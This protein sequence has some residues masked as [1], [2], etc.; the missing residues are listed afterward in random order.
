MPWGPPTAIQ[1]LKSTAQYV[2]A[3]RKMASSVPAASVSVSVNWVRWGKTISKMRDIA[4]TLMMLRQA[5][6]TWSRTE[7]PRR[8]RTT[9]MQ[10]QTVAV[11]EMPRATTTPRKPK[12]SAPI[13][14]RGNLTEI[15]KRFRLKKIL[16]CPNPS[17]VGRGRCK[18]GRDQAERESAQKHHRVGPLLSE[19]KPHKGLRNQAFAGQ[20]GQCKRDDCACTALV[21]PR[22]SERIM[23]ESRKCGEERAQDRCEQSGL[24]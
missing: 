24:R 20:N 21:A 19:N 16:V 15:S 23:A 2:P 9:N 12:R 5:V 14:T 10:K 18:Q 8:R 1:R 17:R 11:S 3:A 22:E 7:T 13:T 6:K 4:S